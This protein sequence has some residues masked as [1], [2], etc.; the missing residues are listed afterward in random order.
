[1]L[2]V[3][4]RK[5]DR[6]MKLTISE[7]G[8]RANVS[9][10][11]LRFYD[12]VGILTPSNYNE[13]G[14][15]LYGLEELSKLQQIQS[16]KFI[17]YSLQDIKGLLTSEKDTLDDFKDSLTLQLQ[18]LENK[19]KEVDQA[20]SAVKRTQTITESGHP[21][22]WTLLSSILFQEE[23]MDDQLQWAKENLSEEI[24]ESFI[25]V[26]SSDWERWDKEMLDISTE[27]KRLIKNNI[28][29]NS[30]EAFAVV[31]KLTHLFT[32]NVEDLEAFSKQLE[33]MQKHFD[34]NPLEMEFHFPN[35]FTQEEADYLEQITQEM[36]KQSRDSSPGH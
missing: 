31:T 3:T 22:T 26:P 19:R 9:V 12:E 10:R 27:V 20:I 25:D 28:P 15:R 23:H 1:M 14:H 29:P 5:G 13:A 18:L 34:N 11:T 6:C 33:D 4:N 2:N 17:E 30:S 24:A 7:F 36:E 8:R 21:I 16:L 35:T 32:E